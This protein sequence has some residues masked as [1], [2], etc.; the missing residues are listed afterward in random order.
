MTRALPLLLVL[1]GATGCA[2]SRPDENYD[3]PR[4][5]AAARF[6]APGWLERA[7]AA[8]VRMAEDDAT[9]DATMTRLAAEK[10]LTDALDAAVGWAR[11]DRNGQ[12]LPCRFVAGGA[13]CGR[14][15]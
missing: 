11:W 4:R 6:D 8:D 2:A 5:P 15:A 1:V 14:H 3:L 7:R 9:T 12:G 13:A 10:R